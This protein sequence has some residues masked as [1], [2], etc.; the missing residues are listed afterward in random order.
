MAA[1]CTD[2]FDDEHF[3]MLVAG[4]R[5]RLCSE[6]EQDSSPA[7]TAED[8]AEIIAPMLQERLT[9]GR[10]I[11][12]FASEDDDRGWEEP[13]GEELDYFL[14]DILGDQNG[15][16][17]DLLEAL[18][19]SEPYDHSDPDGGFFDGDRLYEWRT[20]RP[21]DLLGQWDTASQ[22]IQNRH[23]YFSPA[24]IELF[25]GL[26][27]GLD[28]LCVY[29]D[30]EQPII[31]TL[32]EGTKVYRARDCSDQSLIEAVLREPMGQVGPSP[33]GVAGPGRMNADGVSVLYAA[34]D[35]ETAVSEIRP[36]IGST[37]AV[38]QLMTTRPLKVLDFHLL[39]EAFQGISFFNSDY[40]RLLERLVFIRRLH[41]LISRPVH[42][43]H[44]HEYMITQAMA[45]YL[46][47]IHSEN[48]DG[49]LFKS[50]QREGG[51]NVVL[52]P[53]PHGETLDDYGQFDIP[54][55]YVIDS[56]EFRK[57]KK[58]QYFL[59]TCFEY[60]PGVIASDFDDDFDPY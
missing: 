57:A 11:R 35:L 24:A 43:K 48:V 1:L 15:F 16:L 39:E 60:S 45:E 25:D 21:L 9:Y 44:A 22:Q 26:F 34:Q 3:K 12:K 38:I 40:D 18:F 58:V 5:S 59:E 53:K 14:R 13:Q 7:I 20:V 27:G 2:C 37:S 51:V 30:G 32:P 54:I 56:L 23:R 6:C 4:M 42:P 52:F 36:A 46:A 19:E 33:A 41:D 50:V 10:T 17:P 29:R 8:L 31:S 47:Y 49:I 28:D 55:E